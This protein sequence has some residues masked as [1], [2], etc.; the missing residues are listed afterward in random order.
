MIKHIIIALLLFASSTMATEKVYLDYD[1][2]DCSSHDA[3]YV[4][5]GN[6]V[7]VKT[8]TILRDKNGTFT[9]EANISQQQPCS[10]VSHTLQMS[11]QYWKCPYCYMYWPRG[12]PCQNS[13]CPSRYYGRRL[14][15]P[16]I[17]SYLL[18]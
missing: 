12:T 10:S 4:H 18:E 13:N 17:P 15:M 9:F 7:W 2:L 16:E 1:E 14:E 3:F 5:Q 8:D 6:N 11:P